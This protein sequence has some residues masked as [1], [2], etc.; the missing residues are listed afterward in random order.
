MEN[1]TFVGEYIGNPKFQHLIKYSKQTIIFY[2]VVENKSS[3]PEICW[4]PNQAID[5]FNKY[6]LDSVPIDS[7]GK[8]STFDD[9]CE[10]LEK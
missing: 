8:F 4:L 3:T 7:K 2:S 1:R 6:G 10:C 9:L 5:L